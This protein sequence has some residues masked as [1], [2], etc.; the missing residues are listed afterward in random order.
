VA[1][2]GKIKEIDEK[3]NNCRITNFNGSNIN[4]IFNH[5]EQRDI[6]NT[7]VFHYATGKPW[8]NLFSGSCENIWYKYLSLSPYGYLYKRKFNRPK[9]K[10]LR[11]GIFKYVLFLYIH[12]TPIINNLFKILLPKKIF[13]NLKSFY[14]KN[15]K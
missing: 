7:I 9:Y 12:I 10:I 4:R 8:N 6:N 3:Y 15:I 2:D 1:F 13:N 14:R 5:I 11:L